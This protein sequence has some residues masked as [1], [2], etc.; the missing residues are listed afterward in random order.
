MTAYITINLTAN[1][2]L[3]G[4]FDHR[5]ERSG[6]YVQHRSDLPA[7]HQALHD[8]AVANGHQ[9]VATATRPERDSIRALSEWAEGEDAVEEY[10]YP[11]TKAAR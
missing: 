5:A 1:T 11:K 3:D 2:T 8:A 7:D 6:V 9:Y 4:S 10:G